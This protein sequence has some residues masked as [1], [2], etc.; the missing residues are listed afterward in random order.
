MNPVIET[1]PGSGSGTSRITIEFAK[2][3]ARKVRRALTSR[4]WEKK[5]TKY[6]STRLGY[7]ILA[8]HGRKPR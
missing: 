4:R 8:A 7:A 5:L 3:L 2:P 1:G 6:L